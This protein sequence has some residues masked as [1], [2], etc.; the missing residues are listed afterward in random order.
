MFTQTP[1]TLRRSLDRLRASRASIGLGELAQGLL[2]LRDPPAASLARRVVAAALGRP[3]GALPER[4]EARHL[5]PPEEAVVADVPLARS[6]FVVVDLETTG[7]AP[8][9]CRILEIGAVRVSSLRAAGHFHTLVRAPQPI[10]R[11]IAD[12][13]GIDD[14]MLADAPGLQTAMRG[15]RSWFGRTGPAPFVAHNAR[16]DAGFVARAL[17]DEKLP[18]LCVP[19]FC[20]QR[21]A[22]RVVPELGRTNLDAVCAHFGVP[23]RARHRALGDARATASIWIELVAR[24]REREGIETVGDLLDLQERPTRRSRGCAAAGAC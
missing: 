17:A 1:D 16:F 7:L 15:F 13:T 10:S 12:L 4:L 21:V 3:E 11:A 14:A 6:E 24:A 5:R 9:R 2:A 19:V 22:R 18:P 23:N 8:D 20:S